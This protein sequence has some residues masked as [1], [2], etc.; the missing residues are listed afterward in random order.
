MLFSRT[1]LELEAKG[2]AMLFGTEDLVEATCIR[3]EEEI[4]WESLTIR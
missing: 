3:E 4:S 2:L 1:G